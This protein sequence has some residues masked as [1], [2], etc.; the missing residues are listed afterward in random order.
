MA[1]TLSQIFLNTCRTYLK[2]DLLMAKHEGRYIPISTAEFEA[3]VRRLSAGFREIGLQPGDKIVIFSENRPEWVIT[4][5]AA[6]CTGCISVPVYT[7]L[8]PEQVK[9]I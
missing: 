3:R 2:D 4:D 1:E 9:Y 8:M 6:L 7:S 5:F